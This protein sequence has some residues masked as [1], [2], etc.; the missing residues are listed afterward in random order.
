ML[1]RND[2]P[3]TWRVDHVQIA[4]MVKRGARVLVHPRA[5]LGGQPG[6]LLDQL[7]RG[8]GVQLTRSKPRSRLLQATREL[9]Q[10]V[11]HGAR[12]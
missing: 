2:K 7:E 1:S 9:A 5:G 8:F 6:A 10:N 3:A 4:N 11:G 12:D